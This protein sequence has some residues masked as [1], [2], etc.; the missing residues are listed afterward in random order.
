MGFD[1]EWKHSSTPDSSI[2]TPGFALADPN[3]PF[4]FQMKMAK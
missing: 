1:L 2:V 4:W 3:E